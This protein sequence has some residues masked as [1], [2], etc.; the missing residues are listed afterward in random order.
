[1]R[2]VEPKGQ[3]FVV[4]RVAGLEGDRV[5][6]QG[7]ALTVNKTR[8]MSES[9]CPEPKS[10]VLHPVG[11][12]PVE[13]SCGRVSMGGGFHKVGASVSAVPEQ[14][15]VATVQPGYLFLVSDNRTLHFDSRDFGMLPASACKTRPILRLW[16][17]DGWSDG[18]HRLSPIL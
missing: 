14:K 11:G 8:Y 10:T 5:E 13:I 4:G 3:R 12:N 18:G 9:A 7:S 6:V 17:K 15:I 2:C 1:V 16:G